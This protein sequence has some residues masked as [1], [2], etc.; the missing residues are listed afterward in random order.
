MRLDATCISGLQSESW[1][2]CVLRRTTSRLA[3]MCFPSYHTISRHSRSHWL[4]YDLQVLLG[5][6]GVDSALVRWGRTETVPKGTTSSMVAV[7][8][9]THQ[10]GVDT[11][12]DGLPEASIYREGVL[13]SSRDLESCNRHPRTTHRSTRNDALLRSNHRPRGCLLHHPHGRGCRLATLFEK[14]HK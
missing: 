2:E 6:N 1:P 7:C 14:V 3:R 4:E 5:T 12:T 11:R 8:S 10:P 13:P 9:E